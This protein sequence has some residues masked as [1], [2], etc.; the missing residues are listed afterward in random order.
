[1]T[2]AKRVVCN[3]FIVLTVALAASCSKDED[4]PVCAP[5]KTLL[6]AADYIDY[7]YDDTHRLSK[8]RIN[9]GAQGGERYDLA[10]DGDKLVQSMHF[11]EAFES[12]PE[13]LLEIYTFTYGSDGKPTRR[14]VVYGGLPDYDQH[15]DYTYDD[16]GRLT[17]RQ[18]MFS[19]TPN[20]TTR[21]EYNDDNNVT[22]IYYTQ[23]DDKDEML[24]VE[25]FSFDNHKRFFAAS[26]DLMFFELYVLD[27]EPSANNATALR[28][29]ATPGTVY[30]NPVDI[31]YTLTYNDQGNVTSILSDQAYFS[32]LLVFSEMQYT[33]R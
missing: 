28:I 32:P 26:Q 31:K 15:A 16:K 4:T 22:K 8:I 19:V 3:A 6:F 27:Y 12:S 20:G 1:M 11:V 30:T 29:T 9:W 33:C 10:Y 5:T 18:N 21:Y 24:G 23:P 13:R 7:I 14:K 25:L 17:K 2:P